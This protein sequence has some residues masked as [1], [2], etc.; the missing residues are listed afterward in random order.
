MERNLI[1]KFYKELILD[2]DTQKLL[3]KK[4]KKYQDLL[5]E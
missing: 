1:D 5:P 3:G 4:I 2:G